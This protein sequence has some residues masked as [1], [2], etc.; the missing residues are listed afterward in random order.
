MDR[1]QP[2]ASVRAELIRLV[3]ARSVAAPT[4][5]VE[6]LCDGL[7]A[8]FGS[9]LQGI[10]FYGSC[11]RERQE[12]EGLVDLYVLVDTYRNAY[13]GMALG[14]L[15]WALPPNVF[16]LEQPLAG[17]GVVRAKY[18]VLTLADFRRGTAK[19]WFHSYLWGR[20]AQPCALVYA[21]DPGVAA[22]VHESLAEAVLT[23]VDRVIPCLPERFSSDALWRSG[24]ASSYRA[25]LR[26]EKPER[27]NILVDGDDP[28]RQRITATALLVSSYPVEERDDGSGPL[29]YAEIPA[30]QRRLARLAWAAR[31]VQGKF[32]S[33][34]RL[35]KAVFTFQGGVDYIVWKLERHSGQSIPVTPALRRHPLIFG[36]ALMWRLYRKRVFR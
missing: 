7:R 33:V 10:L 19:T 34:A 16:Y 11:L 27:V 18:A 8:R 24:L 22:E 1:T 26:A 30:R 3:A 9:A 5:G 21:R 23:F 32:L 2:V 36:W 28:D 14:L 13:E 35:S 20:F 17:G 31:R 12:S 25:E 29:F 15:N 4:P 6:S